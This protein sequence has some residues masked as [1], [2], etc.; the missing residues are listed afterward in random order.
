MIYA[1]IPYTPRRDYLTT[2]KALRSDNSVYLAFRTAF[3]QFQFA[4]LFSVSLFALHPGHFQPE[5]LPHLA[6]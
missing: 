4:G 3:I 5:E 1:V 2:E 6:N